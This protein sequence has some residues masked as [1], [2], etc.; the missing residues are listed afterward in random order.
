MGALAGGFAFLRFFC[1]RFPTVAFEQRNSEAYRNCKIRCLVFSEDRKI[2]SNHA[3]RWPKKGRAR[4]TFGSSCVVNDS[5][6]VKIGNAALRS[7]R[8]DAFCLCEVCKLS[9]RRAVTLLNS[10]RLGIVEQCEES[11]GSGRISHH[12][13]GFS[14]SDC[15]RISFQR[16]DRNRFRNFGH[17]EATHCEVVSL[18]SAFEL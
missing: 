8:L 6:H 5:P 1:R 16:Q 13:H 7:E 4:S 18:C 14:N 10:S 12:H 11:I 9:H 2:N 17:I 15:I 3:T